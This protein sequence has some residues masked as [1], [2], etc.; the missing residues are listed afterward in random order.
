MASILEHVNALANQLGTSL[1][2]VETFLGQA[3]SFLEAFL[4]LSYW[5]VDVMNSLYLTLNLSESFSVEGGKSNFIS[6]LELTNNSCLML[7]HVEDPLAQNSFGSLKL[8]FCSQLVL[9][10]DR[11]K[12]ALFVL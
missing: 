8:S 6:V 1:Y 3:L 9:F 5:L 2:L 4:S 7:L 10:E 12:F 11:A